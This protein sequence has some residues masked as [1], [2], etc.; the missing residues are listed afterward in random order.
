MSGMTEHEFDDFAVDHRTRCLGAGLPAPDGPDGMPFYAVWERAFRE[1][2][3]SFR[4]ATEASVRVAAAPP[5]WPRQHRKALLTQCGTIR[6]ERE[7]RAS[8]P[9][10]EEAARRHFDDMQWRARRERTRDAWGRLS[11][12]E[13]DAI[14]ADVLAEFPWAADVPSWAATLC[15]N[16]LEKRSGL[17]T[18]GG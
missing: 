6:A 17:V 1:R 9:A 3:I 5:E 10:P 11:D 8:R 13:R 4:D 7:E 14:C 15:L 2:G 12:A 18:G 16:E